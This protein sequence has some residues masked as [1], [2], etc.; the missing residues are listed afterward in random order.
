MVT[1]TKN[2]QTNKI[3]FFKNGKVVYPISING[4]IA[5]FTNQLI[6]I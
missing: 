5:V 6:L 2:K 4:N 1:F 3:T